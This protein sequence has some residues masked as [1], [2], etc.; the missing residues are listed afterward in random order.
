[1]KVCGKCFKIFQ[2][3]M[4]LKLF[5]SV[6]KCPKVSEVSI[7]ISKCYNLTP[8]VRLAILNYSGGQFSQ[9][10][11]IGVTFGCKFSQRIAFGLHLGVKNWPKI[12]TLV[13]RCYCLG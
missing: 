4:C 3:S 12:L 1:M 10:N 8:V 5:Q 13:L 2:K 6:S 11:C 7:S 9:E